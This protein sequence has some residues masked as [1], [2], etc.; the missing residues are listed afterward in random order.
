MAVQ[1][2]SVPLGAEGVFQLSIFCCLSLIYPL[3]GHVGE[4]SIFHWLVVAVIV[5]FVFG[6]KRL[7]EMGAA[8]GKGIRE[9]KR[10]MTDTGNEPEQ[11]KPAALAPPDQG[12]R[13]LREPVTQS[14][15]PKRLSK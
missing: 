2:P 15:E 14:R 13:T 1:T 7:P 4:F 5:L 10:S 6:A 9:F 3:E 8:M 11:E 12:V